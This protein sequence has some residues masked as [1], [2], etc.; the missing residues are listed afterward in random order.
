MGSPDVTARQD[1]PRVLYAWTADSG[2]PLSEGGRREGGV[3][4][5]RHLAGI[6]LFLAL[7]GMPDD[8]AHGNVQLVHVREMLPPYPGYEYGPVVLH[9]WR[10]PEGGGIRFDTDPP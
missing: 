3:R 9:A 10:C 7:H 6:E 5:H 2:R 4:E 1:E 8:D